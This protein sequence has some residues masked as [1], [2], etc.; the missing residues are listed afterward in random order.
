ME[1]HPNLAPPASGG[2]DEMITDPFEVEPRLTLA[3]H[4]GIG[5]LLV[6]QRLYWIEA[7]GA[8][9]GEKSEDDAGDS[10]ADES[11]GHRFRRGRQHRLS[12]HYAHR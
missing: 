4:H 9:R 10:A 6:P 3:P 1:R 12:F 5:G 11:R 8:R 7:C 2:H